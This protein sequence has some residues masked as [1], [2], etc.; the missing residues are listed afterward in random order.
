MGALIRI[1]LEMVGDPATRLVRFRRIEYDIAAAQARIRAA[2]L[3]ERLAERLES[4][5]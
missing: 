2:G 4:G 1:A 3:P 5:Q